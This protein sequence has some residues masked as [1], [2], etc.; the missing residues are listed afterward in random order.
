MIK[1]ADEILVQNFP[2][3]AL[4]LAAGNQGPGRNI[5]ASYCVACTGFPCE[6]APC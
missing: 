5:A 6:D 1:E 3:A 4:E 2:D